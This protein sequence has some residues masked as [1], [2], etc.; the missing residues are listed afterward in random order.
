MCDQH[1]SFKEQ[2][3]EEQFHLKWNDFQSNLSKS[4]SLLR[5]ETFLQDVTLVSDDFKHMKAHKFVLSAS[6]DY[7]KKVLQN[8]N[9][10]SQ[11]LLCLDGVCSEDLKNILDYVYDGEVK[12]HQEGL[13]RFINIAKK[14]KLE[15]LFGVEDVEIASEESYPPNP[16][17]NPVKREDT[18][19]E[20]IKFRAKIHEQ[21]DTSMAIPNFNGGSIT[22]SEHKQMLYDNVIALGNGIYS[23]KICGKFFSGKNPRRNAIR[24]GEVHM[25]GLSYNCTICDKTFNSKNSLGVHN[26]KFHQF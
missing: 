17:D 15:G 2:R 6:S 19:F 7:F 25:D 21:E 13:D 5:N 1:F 24:H 10:Q 23:C 12:I 3:M 4:F 9:S 26:Y 22:E 8:T 11:T 16:Q 18:V 20:D 14:L